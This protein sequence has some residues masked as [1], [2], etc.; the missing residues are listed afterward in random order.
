MLGFLR[1]KTKWVR[2]SAFKALGQFI[3]TLDGLDVDDK[4]IGFYMRM[5]DSKIMKL[6]SESD[7]PIA[8]AFNF[9]A[10]LKAVGAKRWVDLQK[11]FATLL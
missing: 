5:T 9:P 10:V 3:G 4:L 6:T 2:I 1:D 8:C 11:L 7:L